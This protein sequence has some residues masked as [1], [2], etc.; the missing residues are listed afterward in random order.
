MK[1]AA[2]LAVALTL[3]LP[4]A[5]AA[6][7][8]R[9]LG[10]DTT[11]LGSRLAWYD[12]TTLTRL[13]G[14]AVSLQNH[15]GAWSLSPNG[16]RLAIGSDGAAHLRF[17][18]TRHMRA[19][20]NLALRSGAPRV[21]TWLRSDRLLAAGL[22]A[23]SVVDP[24]QLRVVRRTKLPG[25]LEGGAARLPD[26]L[27]LLLGQDVNGFAPAKVAVVDAEGRV[28]SVTLDRISIGFH[29]VD[30]QYE[31]RRPGFAVDPATRR[32]FVVGGDYTIAEIDLRTLAVTYHGGAS[33]APAKAL[34]GPV[35]SARWLGHGLLAV[36]GINALV[37]EGLRIVDTRDWSTRFADDDSVDLALGDGVLVGSAPFCCPSEFAVYGFDGTFRYRFAL[38][39]GMQ[40]HAQGRYGYVCH[41]SSLDRVIELATGLTVRDNRVHT[42]GGPACATLLY[43]RSSELQLPTY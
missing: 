5:S 27:A 11:V 42:P 37:R 16:S 15:S 29:H 4:A 33:R 17:V 12:P 25:L 34:P 19:I 26:G 40:L 22:T 6:D 14:Q 24:A 38:E 43:G 23:V 28:R 30:D 36:A 35:R 9:V 32:A 2:A 8:Q 41:G 7:G 3:A 18:D 13:P 39:S 31:M 10:I 21:V 1:L 20:G